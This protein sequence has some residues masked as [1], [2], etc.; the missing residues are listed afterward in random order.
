MLYSKK[1]DT[2]YLDHE[3]IRRLNENG[4]IPFSELAKILKVSNSLVHLRIRKLQESGLI[5]GFSVKLNAK[6]YGFE[7]IS[8]TGITTKE[9]HFS[10][11]IAEKLKLIPE[12]VECHLAS[13]KYDL[14]IKIVAAN[15]E[16]LSKIIYEQIHIIEGV[17]GTDSFIS[18][19]ATFE[20]CFPL[21]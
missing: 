4:R 13:G 21:H 6:V 1:N 16:E 18:F 20:K 15:N 19:G 8:Y 7:T 9:A 11:S 17:G 2:D 5:A 3:I 14:F 10:F 12:I